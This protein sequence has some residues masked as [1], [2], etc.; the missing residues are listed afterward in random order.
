M[1]KIYCIIFI[2]S[3]MFNCKKE[4]KT[5]E[6]T[7]LMIDTLQG[8]SFLNKPLLSKQLMPKDSSKIEKFLEAESRY[9]LDKNN[10]ENLIW[11]GRRMAYLGDY[12]KAINMFSEGIQKF[13]EDARF[14]RHR[15]HRY[16][17]TRQV[18][19]A[20]S[21]FEKAV[22]LIQGR[23]D[24]IEP[25]GIPNRLNQPVSSLHTN[26]FYHLGLAYY[27]QANWP[28]ALENFQKCYD[29]STNN[30]M[31]VAATHWLYMILRRMENL[32]KANEV[33]QPITAEMNIIENDGYHQLLLFYK[34]LVAEDSLTGNGSAGASE[35]VRYG[36]AHWYQ[37]NGEIDK[38]KVLY[39]KLIAEGNWAGFGY[40][41]AEVE[42]AR[43]SLREPQ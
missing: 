41:A 4:V 36:I 15:G 11:L 7:I 13:P 19:K 40:L 2:S 28:K 9:N 38:A 3:L 14:Y 12:Q 16:I 34:G 17:S 24:Q 30:D 6:K 25:D 23:D 43:W 29:V 22:K 26:I 8:K 32:E 1:K 20:I 37:Y 18:E 42:L 21:D 27:L 5:L 35:A 10:A 39:K 31:R 33:L